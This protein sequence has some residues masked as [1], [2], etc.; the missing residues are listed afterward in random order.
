MNAT[1]DEKWRELVTSRKGAVELILAFRR[2]GA[3]TVSVF[4]VR[5]PQ[6]LPGMTGMG[7]TPGPRCGSPVQQNR[8][9]GP[10]KRT[11]RPLALLGEG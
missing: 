1:F 7:Q 4:L 3:L 6:N 8:R 9:C 11:D 5:S 2:A 10:K